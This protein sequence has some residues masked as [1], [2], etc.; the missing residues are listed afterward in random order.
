[1][2][3]IKKFA[4]VLIVLGLP[5]LVTHWLL[6]KKKEK[7]KTEKSIAVDKEK[8]WLEQY[9]STVKIDSSLRRQHY[10]WDNSTPEKLLKRTL[11]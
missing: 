4:I 1:M 5:I 11:K 9:Q 6:V 2:K 8:V 3:D 7:E 10:H